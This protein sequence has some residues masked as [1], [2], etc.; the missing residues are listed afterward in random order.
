M[1]GGDDRE[2]VALDGLPEALLVLLRPWRRRVDVLGA[3]EVGP[4]QERVVDEEVL[5]AG[6]A[7]HVP[8]LFPC[9][10]DRVDRLLAG[11]VYDIE[12]AA[13]DARQ[14]DGAIR[15]LA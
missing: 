7:P 5:R 12:P 1:V 2:D 9:G 3:L 4:F 14:L 10:R 15:G 13:G 11:D 8:A 6:L